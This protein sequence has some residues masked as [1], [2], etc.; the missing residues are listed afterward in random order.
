MMAQDV[1]VSGFMVEG[2]G[3]GRPRREP[4]APV[5]RRE[6][7]QIKNTDANHLS[8]ALRFGNFIGLEPNTWITIHWKLVPSHFEPVEQ[9]QR[10]LNH[11]AVWMGRRTGGLDP[12]VY[13][14]AREFGRVAGEH[15]HI[16]AHIPKRLL[17][18]FRQKSDGWL[19]ADLPPREQIGS[20]AIKIDLITPGTLH[21]NV[22]RYMLKES[23][24]EVQDLYGIPRRL[25]RK[26]KRLPIQGKRIGLSHSI[27]HKA[28]RDVD[29]EAIEDR[30]RR[31]AERGSLWA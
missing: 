17:K 3:R 19:E 14:Y 23:S 7:R 5:S 28:Q 20:T 25:K 27:G 18:E 1:V 2:R 26:A 12:I 9:L 24:K 11:L 30:H 21:T 22:K 6:S 4:G 31:K 13:A 10:Y 16:A 8:V 15:V 29:V